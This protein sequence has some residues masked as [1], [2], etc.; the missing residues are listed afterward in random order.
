MVGNLRPL[1]LLRQGICCDILWLNGLGCKLD[2]Q[3]NCRHCHNCCEMNFQRRG[4][5]NIDETL[6]CKPLQHTN[7]EVSVTLKFAT[8]NVATMAYGTERGE[9]VSVKALEILRQFEENQVHI[10]GVQESRARRSQ[11]VENGPYTRLI[12][13][14]ECGN[15]GVE[16]WIN[17]QALAKAFKTVFTAEKDLCVW[18]QSKRVL[19]VRCNFGAIA[20]DVLVLYAPQRGRPPGEVQQWW[21][22]LQNVVA[23]RDPHVTLFCWET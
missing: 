7:R 17:G 3:S 9:G 16:L 18:Y 1:F 11:C 13:A 19:G 21:D 4:A 15:A 22:D 6:R 20:F 12:A 10:I 14:G 23:K 2:Q 5:T 8:A